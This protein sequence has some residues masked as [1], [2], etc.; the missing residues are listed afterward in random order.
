MLDIKAL[1]N[2]NVLQPTTSLMIARSIDIIMTSLPEEAATNSS[3][4]M[5]T[6]TTA[7]NTASDQSVI[8]NQTHQKVEKN[9]SVHKFYCAIVNVII[10]ATQRGV[11]QRKLRMIFV[12][13]TQLHL[14]LIASMF[15]HMFDILTDSQI[16]E[17][18]FDFRQSHEDVE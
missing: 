14:D 1:P 3:I 2:R 15:F 13:Y 8:F 4:T 5:T 12:N 9:L 17:L 16:A 11:L 10:T 7:A 18:V 6:T